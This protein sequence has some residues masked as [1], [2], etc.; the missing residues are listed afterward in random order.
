MVRGTNSCLQQPPRTSEDWRNSGHQGR[1]AASSPHKGGTNQYPA[2][3]RRA[4]TDNPLRKRP[5]P[6]DER[7]LH[8]VFQRYPSTADTAGLAKPSILRRRKSQENKCLQTLQ[9]VGLLIM[10]NP[11]L[12]RKEE[13][14]C[15]RRGR[16][17]RC[18]THSSCIDVFKPAIW[19]NHLPLE[20]R[21]G[22]EL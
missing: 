8:R 20:Y 19:K 17:I 5:K 22:D 3:E 6:P 18:C 21:L 13:S 4:S 12:R 16:K 14:R 1:R 10:Q 9:K 7:L 15:F 2:H 11:G